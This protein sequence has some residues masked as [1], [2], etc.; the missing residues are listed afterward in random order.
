MTTATPK[1]P[2]LNKEMRDAV[3]TMRRTLSGMKYD[4]DSL[5]DPEILVLTDLME[6]VSKS[7]GVTP[8]FLL[9]RYRNAIWRHGLRAFTA[10]LQGVDRNISEK[11]KEQGEE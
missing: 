10:V 8:L 4:P 9:A 7:A 1:H 5:T 6:R 11:E 2:K 3:K